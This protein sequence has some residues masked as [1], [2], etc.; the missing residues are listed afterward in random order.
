MKYISLLLLTLIFIVQGCTNANQSEEN[1]K[2]L[3]KVYGYCDN[4]QRSI[5]GRQ[6]EVCKAR[7]DSAGPDGEIGEGKSISEIFSS[8][9]GNKNNN[10]GQ[11]QVISAVNRELWRG[12]MEVLSPYS[13]KNIDSNVGYIETDWIYD[14]SDTS[15]RCLIKVQ[16]NSAELI[17][18]GVTTKFTCQI[19]DGQDWYIDPQNYDNQS[20]KITLNILSKASEFNSQN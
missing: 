1:L 5:T 10:N 16:I 8:I 6:Y 12:A 2:K 20:Q 17:A 11:V 9:T 7:E 4:P 14:K 3:D 19:K 13:I 18:T 15:R